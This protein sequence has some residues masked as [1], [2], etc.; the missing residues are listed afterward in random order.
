MGSRATSQELIDLGNRIRERRQKVCLS[1][2]ALAEKAGISPNTISRVEGGQM[3]MTV[4]IF[5]KLLKALGCDANLILGVPV[6]P[7]EDGRRLEEMFCRVRNLRQGEQDV[8]MLTMKALM[9]G[10]EKSR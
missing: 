7:S 3:A 5:Q 9:D 2:E 10:L 8:V 1:Q 4:G 6:L